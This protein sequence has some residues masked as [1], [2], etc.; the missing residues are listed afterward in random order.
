MPRPK[1]N[2]VTEMPV[3]EVEPVLGEPNIFETETQCTKTNV[4]PISIRSEP[5]ASTRDWS[6]LDSILSDV[7]TFV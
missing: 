3:L 1:K 7:V 4:V 5:V 2:P 6:E